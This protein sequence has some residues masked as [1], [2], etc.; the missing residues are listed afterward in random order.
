MRDYELTVIIHPDLDEEEMRGVVE[1]IT[2]VIT[3]HKGQVMETALWG[4]RKLAYP[5][6]KLREGY[7]VVMQ[8]QMER[9]RLGELERILKL[10]EEVLRY[11]LVRVGED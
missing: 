2:Q 7:Y 1:K 5:I 9:E 6:R 10:S 8:T 3:S 4:K 11:L